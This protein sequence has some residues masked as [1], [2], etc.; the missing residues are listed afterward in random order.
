M[1]YKY[2][3]SQYVCER[4]PKHIEEAYPKV[5]LTFPYT[6]PLYT[7]LTLDPETGTMHFEGRETTFISP[8]PKEI[9]VPDYDKILSTISGR[10]LKM[11]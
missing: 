9:G 8:T 11:Y 2:L 7:V 4:F 5:K 10:S 1:A 6:D 3:G